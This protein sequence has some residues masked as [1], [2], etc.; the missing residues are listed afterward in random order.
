MAIL[1]FSGDELLRRRDELLREFESLETDHG[2]GAVSDE[3]YNAERN[4]IERELV[5]IM[6][7]LTQVKFLAGNP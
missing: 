4:R 3:R 7:R 2:N 1:K 6:D 5:V